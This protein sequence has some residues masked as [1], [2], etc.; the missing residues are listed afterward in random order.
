MDRFEFRLVC[1]LVGIHLVPYANLMHKSQSEHEG[2]AHIEQRTSIHNY[3]IGAIHIGD[4]ESISL[5]NY[6]RM[7]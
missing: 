2:A 6:G 5:K 3:H 7:P 4:Y 1:T